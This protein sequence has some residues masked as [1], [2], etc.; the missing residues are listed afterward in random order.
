MSRSP[1]SR[2]T[3]VTMAV[4]RYKES[5]KHQCEFCGWAP[6]NYHS[7]L[8]GAG[9]VVVQWSD[10]QNRGGSANPGRGQRHGGYEFDQFEAV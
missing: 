9:L 7:H 4:R 8:L 6:P 3:T 1:N 2:S 10:D 5:I